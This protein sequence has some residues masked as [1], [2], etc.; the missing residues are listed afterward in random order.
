MKYSF[1]SIVLKILILL[2]IILFNINSPFLISQTK[3]NFFPMNLGNQ[4]L[5]RDSTR[6]GP[7]LT[8]HAINDKRYTI[9]DTMEFQGKTLYIYDYNYYYYN[10]EEQKLYILKNNA[11]VLS[12]D[13]SSPAT[14]SGYVNFNGISKICKLSGVYQS[15]FA[16]AFRNCYSF[17]YD[18][19]YN[20]TWTYVHNW[21]KYLFCENIGLIYT[22]S[23]SDVMYI[24]PPGDYYSESHDS[25]VSAIVN[26][27][28]YK[29][30]APPVFYLSDSLRDRRVDEF[31]FYLKSYFSMQYPEMITS[32]YVDVQGYRDTTRVYYNRFDFNRAVGLAKIENTSSVLQPGDSLTINCVLTYSIFKEDTIRIPETGTLSF[33]VLPPAL[34]VKDKDYIPGKF[35]ISGYPNPFN[36]SAKIRYSIP[37]QS[38]IDLEI[39]SPLGEKIIVLESGLRTPGIHETN[40]NAGLTPSGIYYVRLVSKSL[41]SGKLFAKTIKMV[42]LK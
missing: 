17:D 41:V 10:L 23:Y 39:F 38:Y 12:I 7:P 42:Y 3:I 18:E 2:I 21:G 26:N 32:A 34:S 5:I 40:W 20:S 30:I 22:Y 15:Y 35:D 11:L 19:L 4:Y 28:T 33:K 27:I 13:F 29:P 25:T 1:P 24:S 9:S 14:D 36:P 16:D 8:I 37:D 31:P 6:S